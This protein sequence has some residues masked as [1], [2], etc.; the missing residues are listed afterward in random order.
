MIR[1]TALLTL[2]VF[3]FTLFTPVFMQPKEAEADVSHIVECADCVWKWV[4]SNSGTITMVFAGVTTACVV[5]KTAK[6]YFSH[7]K[8]KREGTR[9]CDGKTLHNCRTKSGTEDG[10]DWAVHGCNTENICDC[11]FDAKHGLIK[12]DNKSCG[13]Y[14]RYTHRVCTGSHSCWEPMG[15]SSYS[16][17]YW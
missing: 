7:N 9:D 15:S 10:L 14:N 13:D 16:G 3:T 4:E 1:N 11:V 5:L 12:C 8:C 17:S 6:D 2:L